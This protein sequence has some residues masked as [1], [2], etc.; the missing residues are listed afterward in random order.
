[1]KAAPEL[2]TENFAQI[3]AD[4]TQAADDLASQPMATGAQPETIVTPKRRLVLMTIGFYERV[5]N[6]MGS[7]ASLVST[8]QGQ[9]LM[10]EVGKAL[11][12]LWKFVPF[13]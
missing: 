7:T 4:I 3:Q 2:T 12:A 8:P 1:V 6:F 9:A 13:K 11:E 5:Y 10:V